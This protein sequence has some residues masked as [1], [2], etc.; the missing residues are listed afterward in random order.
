MHDRA[1]E[2]ID[3]LDLEAHP[4]G[5]YYR[6][7]YES[8]E[9][10]PSDVLPAGYESPRRLGSSILFLLPAEEVSRLH[11]LRGDEMWHFYEGASLDIHVFGGEE[12]YRTLRLGSDL[13]AGEFPQHVVRGG[14]W[15]GATVPEEYALV[16]CT[17]W[18]EFRFEDFE[19]ADRAELLRQYP[20]QQ[21]VIE[22][23][24]R[25]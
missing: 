24:T 25:G 10:I 1:R 17:V 22:R 3:R 7:T 8:G 21:S 16:G 9:T 15:F 11:R 14:H 13:R 23:L 6:R 18:P 2:L 19:M 5:G 20:D 12:G 4:E